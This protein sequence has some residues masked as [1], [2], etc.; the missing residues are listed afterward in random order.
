[1]YVY[2]TGYV[3]TWVVL[4]FPEVKHMYRNG[5]VTPQI[6]RK[7]NYEYRS[8]KRYV[9]EM[10]YNGRTTYPPGYMYINI[11]YMG[12]PFLTQQSEV[13]MAHPNYNK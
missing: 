1:M 5:N 2:T 12:G 11:H 13:C 9:Y 6:K 3:Y 8:I 10:I 4:A 7:G